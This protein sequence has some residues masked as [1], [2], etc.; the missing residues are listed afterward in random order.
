[1]VYRD[2]ASE[3]RGKCVFCGKDSVGEGLVDHDGWIQCYDCIDSERKKFIKMAQDAN[4]KTV[5]K[6]QD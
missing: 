5:V 6:Q 1:M 3:R 2:H 4:A